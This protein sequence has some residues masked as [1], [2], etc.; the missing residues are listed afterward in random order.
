MKRIYWVVGVAA[1]AASATAGNTPLSLTGYNF[2]GIAD[3]SGT[4]AGSTTG[5]L[6]SIYDY[7]TKGFDAA[8]PTAGLP[9]TS[10][11]SAFNASTTFLLAAPSGDNLLWLQ[12]HGSGATSGTLTLAAPAT[13]TTLAFLVTG[14]NGS[15]PTG[16]AL[17]FASGTPTSGSFTSSD[18]F[19]QTGYAINGFG[20]VSRSNGVFDSIG[21]TNPRLYE[22]D[23]TLSSTDAL[24]TLDSVT[25]TN[26]ETSGTTFH[27]VGVFAISG[28]SPA[29]EP[30]S[31]AALGLGL[32]ALCRRRRRR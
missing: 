27:D 23:V 18:N 8:A 12:Q 2:D 15:Q 11:I 22:I 3:G 26:N 1:F 25:F 31:L 10:F 17:N 7:F 29:P 9:T 28:A 32:T 19:N 14:F 5:T 24:R 4:A 13:F 20:R 30:A 6:D 16:Y 21:S